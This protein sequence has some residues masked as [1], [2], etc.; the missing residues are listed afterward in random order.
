MFFHNL[1]LHVS[2]IEDM[3][4]ILEDQGHVIDSHLMSGHNWALGK[5]RARSGSG[6]LSNG[7]KVG[8]GSINLATW[9]KIVVEPNDTD[10]IVRAGRVW[11]DE[12]PQLER[13]DGYIVTYPP[14]F[15]LLYEKFTK[16]IVINLP[17]R[18][19][20]MVTDNS[21]KWSKFNR[22]L[23]QG[24]DSGRIVVAANS[25]Y[26]AKYY[27]YF[28]GRPA[29]Y[30]SSTCCYM[31]RLAPG[32]YSPSEDHLIA[33]GESSGCREAQTKVTDVRFVRDLFPNSYKH[34]DIA[35]ARGI[36]WIPYNVSI[37]SFFEHYRMNMPMFVPTKRFLFALFENGFSLSQITWH[38]ST[39]K[40]SNL[41][42]SGTNLPDP[43]TSR[44]VSLWMPFYDFYN[45]SEF[46]NITYFDSWEELSHKTKTADFSEISAN[47]KSRNKVREILNRSKWSALIHKIDK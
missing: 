17:I 41:P 20:H 11:H 44:G 2:V 15:S 38:T 46:P 27:E 32:G 31:D 13:Y 37:M 14:V 39:V 18:Y 4:S 7:G 40:G 34:S 6:D 8:Y 36:V 33:F 21:E 26:D 3:I 5:Q 35:H 10:A 29:E 42:R 23:V 45:E 47:M 19:D 12:N 22:F 25:V 16:P 9:E 24:Q 1:D 43:H 28:T 30:I